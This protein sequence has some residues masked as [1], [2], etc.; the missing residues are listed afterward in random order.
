[1][2]KIFMTFAVMAM[3]ATSACQSKGVAQS[4]ENNTEATSEDAAKPVILLGQGEELPK[5]D[6]LM[7]LDFNAVWCGPCRKFG[8]EFEK[9]AETYAGKAVF[10][11][12]D[13]DDCP[14]I[15]QKF[16]VEVIPHVAFVQPDGTVNSYVGTEELAD[17][18]TLV[19]KYIH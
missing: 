6:R 14:E 11:S 16:G 13:V 19:E 2:K 3:L 17:F 4:N 12:V 7:V 10:V 9:A 18:G 15:A 8:P 1:M 5:T